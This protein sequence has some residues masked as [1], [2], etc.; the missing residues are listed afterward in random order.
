M[1][2]NPYAASGVGVQDPQAEDSTGDRQAPRFTRLVAVIVDSLLIIPLTLPVQYA[3]G[4][5]RSGNLEEP[6]F[7]VQLGLSLWGFCCFLILNG[8]PLAIRGQTI[9]KILTHIQI[10]DYQTGRR[11]PFVRVFV[12]RYLWMVPLSM[13]AMLIPGATDNL[14][15]SLVALV[16]ALLIFGSQQRCLHDRLAGSKVV[17]YRANRMGG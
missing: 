1:A 17:M 9:G 11:L 16:D 3:L 7:L 14:L 2:E 15:V 8:Y 6:G 5:F 4:Y 12:V 13:V 10:A